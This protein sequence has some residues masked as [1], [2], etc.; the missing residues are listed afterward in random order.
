MPI[1]INVQFDTKQVV[2]RMN[3]VQKGVKNLTEPFN[4]AK[5][6]LLELYGQ[7][8]FESQGQILK[9]PWKKLSP[10]TL[11]LRKERRGHYKKEPIARGKILIWTGTLIKGFQGVVKR[12]QLEISNTVKYFKEN[13]E[14]RKMLVISDPAIVI[15]TKSIQ[16]YLNKLGQ[17]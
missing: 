6:Q 7:K 5:D 10:V 15:V 4:E 17:L 12:T 3:V 11:M 2:R 14:K 9:K 8:N 1:N 16:K 13:Q